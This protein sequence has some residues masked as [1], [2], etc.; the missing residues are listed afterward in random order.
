MT[1]LSS[2][3]FSSSPAL[4]LRWLFVT[5]SLVV[6]IVV[7]TSWLGEKFNLI[8]YGYFKNYHLQLSKLESSTAI[9]TLFVGDSSLGALLDIDVWSQSRG[10][11]SQHLALTGNYGYAGSLNMLQRRLIG[12]RPRNVVIFQ[13]FD[14]LTRAP[15]YLGYLQTLP[16]NVEVRGVPL[17]VRITEQFKFYFSREMFISTL[18][19]ILND[20]IGRRHNYLGKGYALIPNETGAPGE[21]VPGKKF[22]YLPAAINPEKLVFLKQLATLCNAEKLNCVYAHGPVYERV[23]ETSQTYLNAVSTLI[24]STG[25]KVVAGT[26]VCVPQGE[27][28]NTIDHI[29]Q[30]LKTLYTHRYLELLKTYLQ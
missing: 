2:S 6:T 25:L 24:K 12:A 3:T 16:D 28:A 1:S 21:I 9:D 23:C 4:Y 7:G 17:Q 29:R 20:L 15:A 13:T 22:E 14:M 11:P 8:D 19:G 27:L 26:P 10:K 30:D 18:R 5:V